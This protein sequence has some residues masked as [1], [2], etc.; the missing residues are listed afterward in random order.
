[1]P[2]PAQRSKHVIC[3]PLVRDVLSSQMGNFTE[4]V[5][6]VIKWR[7]NRRLNRFRKVMLPDN[8]LKVRVP[9]VVQSLLEVFAWGGAFILAGHKL[10]CFPC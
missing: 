6:P 1:M 9:R 5:I 10:S 8:D 2:S 4:C 3:V 7:I